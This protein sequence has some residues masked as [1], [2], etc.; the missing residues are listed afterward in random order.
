MLATI[1]SGFRAPWVLRI[2]GNLCVLPALCSLPS[3]SLSLSLSAHAPPLLLSLQVLRI[4]LFLSL[5]ASTGPEAL[6]LKPLL[7]HFGLVFREHDQR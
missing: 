5:Y 7:L 6:D 3:F 1:H 4:F 2:Y